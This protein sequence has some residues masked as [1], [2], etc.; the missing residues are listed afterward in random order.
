MLIEV[1]VTTAIGIY[2]IH[3]ASG[4][5]YGDSEFTL[6][7]NSEVFKTSVRKDISEEEKIAGLPLPW[8]EVEYNFIV[9]GKI[10]V[11]RRYGFFRLSY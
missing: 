7:D 5:L 1:L 9:L 3:Y 4:E 8:S 6:P 10:T 11:Q 2:V